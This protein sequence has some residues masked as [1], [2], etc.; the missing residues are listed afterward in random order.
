MQFF[1]KNTVISDKDH[2]F[3]A[4]LVLLGHTKELATQAYLSAYK[5]V[6]KAADML[7]DLKVFPD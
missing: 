3:I 6:T 4:K 7:Y 5:N 2:D 1:Q